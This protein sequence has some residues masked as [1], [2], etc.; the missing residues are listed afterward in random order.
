MVKNLGGNKSKKQGR[1]YAAASQS[2][3]IREKKV[4]GEIYASVN[5][6]FGGANCEVICEDGVTRQCIIRGNFR[7]RGKSD[8]FIAPGVWI[9]VGLRDWEIKHPD[10]K[11]TCDLLC[12]Y[13]EDEKNRLITNPKVNW[14]AMGATIITKEEDDIGIDFDHGTYADTSL[15]R[16]LEL[17]ATQ[18]SI[19]ASACNLAQEQEEDIDIDDI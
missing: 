12:V 13:R 9:L 2:T 7:G 14:A 15:M 3:T 19:N 1:K 17:Q 5:K 8:N 16:S 18:T 6:L 10:K 4:E 11:E